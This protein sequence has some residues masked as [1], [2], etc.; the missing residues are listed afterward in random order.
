MVERLSASQ[1]KT[2]M[3]PAHPFDNVIELHLMQ[4]VLFIVCSHLAR[5]VAHRCFKRR[6]A[7]PQV[8]GLG[9]KLSAELAQL[10]RS[11][12]M[13]STTRLSNSSVMAHLRR[14]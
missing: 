3:Y 13:C 11:A 12:F 8:L 7:E 4:R 9:L 14:A 5:E 10:I 6:H 1:F 2:E